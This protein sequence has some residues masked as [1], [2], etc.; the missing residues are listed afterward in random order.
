MDGLSLHKKRKLVD[1]LKKNPF[2]INIDECTASSGM[3]V[4]TI[5][6]SYFDE[7]IGETVVEH[8]CS[9]ECIRVNAEELFVKICDVFV[10]DEIPF[11]LTC[12]RACFLSR[13]LDH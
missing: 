10:K 1:A 2:S 8:Y 6:V 12:V 13:D 11:K 5:I 3:K 7:E 4:F 9:F